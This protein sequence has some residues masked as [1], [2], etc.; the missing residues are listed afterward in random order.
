MKL[1]TFTNQGKTRIG[2]WVSRGAENFILDLNRAQPGLPADMV[3]FLRAGDPAM[4][5]AQSAVA[6]AHPQFLLPQTQ[7]TLLAPVPRPGN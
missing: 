2:A 3:E 1:V 6:A 4:A 5:L 7:A